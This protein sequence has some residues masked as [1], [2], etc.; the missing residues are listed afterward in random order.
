[1]WE[2]KLGSLKLRS[3]CV[4]LKKGGGVNPLKIPSIL[5]FLGLGGPYVVP[6]SSWGLKEDFLSVR[7][8]MTYIRTRKELDEIADSQVT[9][10]YG[11]N[12]TLR[13]ATRRSRGSK[14][15]KSSLCV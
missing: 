6:S 1:M 13:Q 11:M 5:N 14:H 7:Y 15:L 10:N 8:K 2:D 4:R 12:E 3:I 9:E